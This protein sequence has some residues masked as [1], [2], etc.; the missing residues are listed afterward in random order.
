MTIVS[1]FFF[2][3]SPNIVI[4]EVKLEDQITHRLLWSIMGK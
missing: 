3:L 1:I 4:R 2:F